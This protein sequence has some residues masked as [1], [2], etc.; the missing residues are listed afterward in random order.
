M[1]DQLPTNRRRF[2]SGAGAIAAALLCAM[3]STLPATGAQTITVSKEDH[4]ID[5]AIAIYFEEANG[6]PKPYLFSMDGQL[7]QMV[8]CKVTFD[9]RLSRMMTIL[10]SRPE[11]KHRK[12]L[13]AKCVRTSEKPLSVYP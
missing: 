8:M 12:V 10:R 7:I 5:T 6:K 9:S 2:R 1:Q 4:R 3:L 11:Y 13:G